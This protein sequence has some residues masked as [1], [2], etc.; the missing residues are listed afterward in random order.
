MY[1]VY[2]K[3]ST[4][5]KLCPLV[6]SGILHFMPKTILGLPGYVLSWEYVY[7]VFSHPKH[8]RE[9]NWIGGEKFWNHD[10]SIMFHYRYFV[11]MLQLQSQYKSFLLGAWERIANKLPH[12]RA[13]MSPANSLRFL[14]IPHGFEDDGFLLGLTSYN[15]CLLVCS[16]PRIWLLIATFT[17]H[18]L[19]KHDHVAL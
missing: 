18:D 6:G 14:Y 11:F 2:P 10:L 7:L 17:E 13:V 16:M 12:C 8:M 3:K 15:V 5:T 9:S 19:Q 1:T 4:S